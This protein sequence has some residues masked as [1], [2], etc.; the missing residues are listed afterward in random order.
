MLV[1]TL[2][3]VV[4]IHNKAC[5]RKIKLSHTPTKFK[6]NWWSM[7]EKESNVEAKVVSSLPVLWNCCH[8]SIDLD[9]YD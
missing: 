5:V 9:N 8:N 3:M 1:V 7:E 4:S 6:R 2:A